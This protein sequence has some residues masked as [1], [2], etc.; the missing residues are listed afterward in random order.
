MLKKLRQIWRSLPAPMQGRL[1]RL[2]KPIGLPYSFSYLA[3][4]SEEHDPKNFAGNMI[5]LKEEYLRSDFEQRQLLAQRF[6]DMLNILVLAN[7]VRKTTYSRRQKT[8]LAQIFETGKHALR[9]SG[10]RVLDVPSST[11]IASV[12]TYEFLS[13]YFGISEYVLG[14]LCFRVL[15]DPDRE[16]V[17]DEG[18]NLL[19]VM[20]NNRFVS[21]YRPHKSG[22]VYNAFVHAMLAPLDLLSWRH[23]RRYPYRAGA[24]L[25][26]IT[27]VHPDVEAFVER[28]IFTLQTLDVFKPIPGQY[29]LILSFNLLQ[30]NYFP[31][32]RIAL[33]VANLANA[34]S[35]NGLLV[36]G[37]ND[38]YSLSR[39]VRGEL[40]VLERYGQF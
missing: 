32:D 18:G 12:G 9:D 29:D 24:R 37:N 36:R 1:Y 3:K 10:V 15:Y 38:K 17:F 35:E 25:L 30:D 8:I 11:G 2:F 28:G 21:I 16:C 23:K 14:D 19:Q 34:L 22:D 40:V 26:P 4:Y 20:R 13:Q 31:Q 7:G 27:L 33:G 5:A 39:K 6:H